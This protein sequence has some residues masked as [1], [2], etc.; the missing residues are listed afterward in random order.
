MFKKLIRQNS[1]HSNSKLWLLVHF[2]VRFNTVAKNSFSLYANLYVV[3][4]FYVVQN[5]IL[6]LWNL[7][8]LHD[9]KQAEFDSINSTTSPSKIVDYFYFIHKYVYQPL[10]DWKFGRGIDYNSWLCFVMICYIYPLCTHINILH[11][12]SRP[13]NL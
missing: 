6:I 7:C 13:K 5:I 11:K 3:C 9:V 1:F 2:F 10:F 4:N 12:V 8:W